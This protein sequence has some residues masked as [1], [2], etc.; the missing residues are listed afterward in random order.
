MGPAE[1]K[2]SGTVYCTRCGHPNR[3]G[4]RFCSNCGAPLQDETTLGIG[5]IEVEP[6][7]SPEFP[8][9]E[10]ELEAG[11]ALLLVRNG[12]NAGS[13]F[14]IDAGVPSTS[15]G[16]NTESDVFLDDVT[17]SRK[18]AEIRRRGEDFEVHDLGS[19]NGTYVNRER[20]ESTVL[21]S[22]DEIQVGKFK[23]AFFRAGT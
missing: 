21:A 15:L 6:D 11:Q 18:H 8:F 9:P 3:E 5:P 22:G 10:D 20:V 17:V 13:T 2:R 7:G 16:R 1:A 14:L 4:A 12:P 19:L 23:L